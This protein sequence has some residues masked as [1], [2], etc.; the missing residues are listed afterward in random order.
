MVN[1]HFTASIM[2]PG[3]SAGRAC[4]VAKA[5]SGAVM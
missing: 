2:D 1:L 5:C 4:V 3:L